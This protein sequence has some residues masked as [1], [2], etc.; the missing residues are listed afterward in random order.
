[1]VIILYGPKLLRSEYIW[2]LWKYQCVKH[3]LVWYLIP[4]ISVIIG[5]EIKL[6]AFNKVFE[7]EKTN[8]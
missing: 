3:D 7:K 2:L 8:L 4:Y 5:L 6:Q 1:M